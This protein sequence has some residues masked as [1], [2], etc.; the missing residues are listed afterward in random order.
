MKRIDRILSF[1]EEKSFFFFLSVMTIVVF[2]QVI[3]RYVLKGSLPWSEE[4]SRYCMVWVTFIGVSAGIKAGTHMG[5]DALLL[6][7]PAKAGFIVELIQKSIVLIS[8]AIFCVI[9]TQLTISLF[10][11]GQKTATLFIPTAIAYLAMPLGFFGGVIRSAQ[12]VFEFVANRNK[13]TN[14]VAAGGE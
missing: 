1:L 9:S 3:F 14:I 12:K 10:Q 6:V 2:L 11:S 13:K 4:L 8:C 5:L 7:L